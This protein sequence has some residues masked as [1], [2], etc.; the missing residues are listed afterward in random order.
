MCQL[1]RM[2]SDRECHAQP[3][4]RIVE[5]SVQLSRLAY[6]STNRLRS[7]GDALR[8][9]LN[10]ILSTAIR[11]NGEDGMTGGLVF[12][13]SHFMQVLEGESTAVTRTFVRIAADPRHG[14]VTLVEVKPVDERLF[15][16]WSMGYAGET[17]LFDALC[18]RYC[19][20]AGF[21]P[22]GMSADNLVM[23]ILE[24]VMNEENETL[25]VGIA[26]A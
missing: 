6:Y 1:G 16:R 18:A 19:G 23:L 20:A 7:S 13:R 5:R 2:H 12:N 4:C 26:A 25:P 22:M 9:D 11:R 14:D 17:P 3:S 15:G 10:L 24:L 8:A 21:D